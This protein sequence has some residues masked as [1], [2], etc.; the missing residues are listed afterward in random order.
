M[1]HDIEVLNAQYELGRQ[2][3]RNQMDARREW[4][5]R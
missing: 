1:E 2:D 4:M 3:A 5:E